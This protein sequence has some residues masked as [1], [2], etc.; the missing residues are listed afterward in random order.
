MA[1]LS[2]LADRPANWNVL[3]V[4]A[5]N[6]GG[7]DHQLAASTAAAARGATVVALTLPHTM[8]LR[9]SFAHGAILD[10][11][12]GWREV[13]GLPV[14]ERMALLSDPARRAAASTPRP[15]QR[16][17]ASS[18]PW[19]GGRTSSW[20]RPSTPPTPGTR[21]ARCAT[22]PPP[23][24]RTPSTPCSTSSSPTTCAPG[25]ARPSPSP[26]PTGSCGPG[27]G[28]TPARWWGAPTPARIST[29]CAAPS[30]PPPSSAT[31][32][33]NAACCRGRRRCASSPR[34]RPASTGCAD[35][36]RL[37]E[38]SCADLVLFDPERI[39][40]GPE[41]TRDDLPGGA[42]RLYAEGEG[43]E[44]VLVNGTEIVTAGS[45]T[46]AVPGAVLR[47]GP[48]PTPSG[49][50][51]GRWPR[52][53][54][55]AGG[56]STGRAAVVHEVGGPVVVEEIELAPIGPRDVLVQMAASGVCHSDLSVQNGS[57]PF[58]FP[59]VLGHEGAG[60]VLEVGE[61]VT[62]GGRGRPRRADVDAAVPSLLL[63]PGRPA[64]AVRGRAERG[65]R[66]ARTPRWGGGRS[67]GA[68]A[69]PPSGSRPSSPRARWCASTGR[70]PSSWPPW[71][72]ARWPRA[73]GRC[74]T[75]PR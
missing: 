14:P 7:L 67:C 50:R 54:R 43:I 59:T 3:G 26:R 36:G 8:K 19:P 16:R 34:S 29:S 1:T 66:R 22:S 72:A 64:H 33:A 52:P 42:S 45:F 39:G 20:T 23:P 24:E 10:G 28:R 53:A 46:G 6:P 30:T 65:A 11:L 13:F 27:C 58:L 69:P 2:L 4:S 37:A 15:S 75:P 71:W 55:R 5:M 62:R 17:P 74:G 68:S 31:G 56:R 40:H 41:R 21:G 70:S 61:A 32:C 9:L 35:R 38:G 49:H 47:S 60:V 44:H 63:V 48:T 51:R 18:A 73:W 57:I 12:P 25:C